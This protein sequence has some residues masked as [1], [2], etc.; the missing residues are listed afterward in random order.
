MESATRR[1][2]QKVRK[3]ED[4]ILGNECDDENKQTRTQTH[5][6]SFTLFSAYIGSA[7]LIYLL[8]YTLF[9]SFH[10]QLKKQ[11][12]QKINFAKKGHGTI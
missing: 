9:H 8:M 5:Y 7:G 11:N 1:R 4:D 12:H 2:N 6:D 10:Q 3:V